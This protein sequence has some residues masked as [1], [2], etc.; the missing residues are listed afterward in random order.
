MPKRQTGKGLLFWVVAL[1]GAA[2]ALFFGSAIV[3]GIM[4]SHQEESVRQKANSL[5]ST[6]SLLGIMLAEM[7]RTKGRPVV[8]W[9]IGAIGYRL[10]EA[11][12]LEIP[13]SYAVDLAND[14]YLVE[15][16]AKGGFNARHVIT[17][18]AMQV[19][20]SPLPPFK[21]LETQSQSCARAPR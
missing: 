17:G 15:D 13:M 16:L 21:T 20:D 4:Q 7:R 10:A 3:A 14:E 12:D 6:E 11:R 9:Y 18:I 8:C 1:A 19:Y 2:V 5:T